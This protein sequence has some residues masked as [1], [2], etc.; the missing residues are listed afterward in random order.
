[1]RQLS[2]QRRRRGFTLIEILVVVIIIAT[3]AAAVVLSLSGKPEEAAV[4][5][6]KADISTIETALDMFRLDMR[7]YPNEEEGLR[8]L[9][10]SDALAADDAAR[11]KGPYLKRLQQDPWQN[12]YV[13]IYPGE[14]NTQSYD[15]VSYGADGQPGGGEFNTDIGNWTE[16]ME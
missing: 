7:R 3:L 10:S 5:R 8:A 2:I 12:D 11:W 1:M 16:E 6:A 9:V 4:S 14:M 13:Y 15:L